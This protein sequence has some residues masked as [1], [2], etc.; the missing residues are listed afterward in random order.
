MKLDDYAESLAYEIAFW[1]QG[2]SE[3]AYPLDELGKLSLDISTQF[4]SLA[5]ILLL[6]NGSSDSFHHNLIRSARSRAT[7]LERLDRAGIGDDHHQ[8]SGRY[9]PLLDAIAAGDVE[10]AR[11]IVA[12][13]PL[14]WREGH[15]YEDDYCYAQAFHRF[16]QSPP[17][18]DEVPP[19]LERL[20]ANLEGQASARL[21]V[22]QALLTKDQ[23]AFDESFDA[24]LGEREAQIAADKAR[25]QLEDAIIVAQR[26]VFVEG[27]AVLR[28]AD[29]RG[30]ET[31]P[32]YA[33]CPSLARAPMSTPF[34]AE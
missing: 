1:F 7:Y 15:E 6:T 28:L 16:V 2:L 19:L 31:A 26:H 8:A 23:A 29:Q 21:A 13:S 24:L 14:E 27:L 25:G 33:M 32:E 34:P 5:I 20:E 17:L 11:R 10:L 18:D 4:R 30:L 22:C 3:P 9:E 12:L